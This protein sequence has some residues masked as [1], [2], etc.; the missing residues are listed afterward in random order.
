MKFRFPIIIID[1]D[2]RSENSSGLGIRALAREIGAQQEK[3]AFLTSLYD[4]AAS[5]NKKDLLKALRAANV[6]LGAFVFTRD[7]YPVLTASMV[8]GT[9]ILDRAAPIPPSRKHL[10]AIYGAAGLIASLAAG[11][12]VVIVGAVTS[13]RLRRRDDVARTLGA[14]V[15]LS[16]G[17]IGTLWPLAR[18]PRLAGGN[19]NQR[20][21]VA[22]LRSA[23]AD[24][25]IALAVVPV[26]N[27]RRAVR[28]IAGGVMCSGRQARGPGRSL[29]RRPCC[30]PAR[31]Q[32][33]RH[34]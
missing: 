27:G 18:S 32:R 30:T 34:P 26:D 8:Q 13:N 19:A 10:A 6:A 33:A 12:G 25:G 2:F 29:G 21:I 24:G 16:V 5:E 23:V 20:R 15:G 9:M 14:P 28:R 17:K 7:H 22:H 3:V 4:S 1:E 11:L 31:C